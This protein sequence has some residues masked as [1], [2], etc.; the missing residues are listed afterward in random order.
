MSH[1]PSK[2][3]IYREARGLTLRETGKL[4][5]ITPGYLSRVERGEKSLSLESTIRLARVL[6]LKDVLRALAPFCASQRSSAGE[7]SA[8]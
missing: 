5:D 4:S 6:G 3:R 1:A 7:D 2:L 8:A